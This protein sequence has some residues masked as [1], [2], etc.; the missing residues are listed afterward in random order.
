[1]FAGLEKGGVREGPGKKNAMRNILLCLICLLGVSTCSQDIENGLD[2]SPRSYNEKMTLIPS[3]TLVILMG[4][5]SN[6][7]S[8]YIK[9][10]E[11]NGADYL[12]VVN[13][14]TNELEFYDLEKEE[15]IE[16]AA[17]S[18]YFGDALPWSKPDSE[19]H[20]EFYVSSNS[21]RELAYDDEN[22][23]M[24]RIAYRGVDYVGPDGQR[25]NWDN[26]SP[27]VVIIN[28]D[29]E[30]LGEVDLSQ[31]TY[32]TRSYFT[33]DSKLYLSLNHPENNP[34]EDR[35]VFV[36]FKPEKL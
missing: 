22:G 16:K 34:S 2:T 21:Y 19:R 10:V 13:E 4:D 8:R 32:D 31:N 35:M 25:R 7:Y 18:K 11:I 26:K 14:S 17:G 5:R 33:Y 20:E 36:G 27:S 9:K 15:L 30:K 28:E 3:D 6:I 1:M 24:Y 29:F 12:G 23:T